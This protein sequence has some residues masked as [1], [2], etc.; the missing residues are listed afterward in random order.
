MFL[1][2]ALF[3]GGLFLFRNF[4]LN[5]LNNQKSVLQ[6]LEIEFEPKTVAELERVSRAIASAQD[7]LRKHARL[8]FVFKL[9]ED[10]TLNS[11]NFSNFS[12][13][14]DKNTAALSGE[15]ASYGDVSL[16]ANIFESLQ[17]A[18]SATFGSLAL[19][20]TGN[21]SF[22]LNIIFKK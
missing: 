20:D 11:V 1:V 17:E 9:I 12:Y 4:A 5:N 10:N 14:A 13:S 2:A 16:Q 15:A 8:S 6:K 22:A 7:I 3:T 18:A 19:K 21:V